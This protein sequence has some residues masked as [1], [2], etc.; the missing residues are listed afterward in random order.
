MNPLP[1]DPFPLGATI[2]EDG[3]NFSLFS[4]NAT[5]VELLLFDRP[6]AAAPSQVLRL[7]PA[8]NKT[9]FFWNI[10]LPGI[11]AGQIYG[12]RVHGPYQPEQGLRFNHN[13]VLLDP[14]ARAVANFGNWSRS[15]ALGYDPNATQRD[16]SFNEHDNCSTALKSV[17]IDSRDFDWE[18][19]QPINRRLR[20]SVIY[21]MHVRGFTKSPGSAVAHPGTFLGV[22]EKIPYLQSLGITAIE[23]LPIH[24]FDQN[25]NPFVNPFTGERLKNY[26]GYNSVNFFA[27]HPGYCCSNEGCAQVREFQTMVKALHRAGL[28][29][30]LDVAFNHTGESHELGPTISMRGVDNSVYYLLGADRR[31]YQNFSGT[32]NT[33]NCNQPIVRKMIIDSLRYWVQEM[34]VDGFRFDLASILTR[35]EDGQPLPDPPLLWEI[36]IDPTLAKTKLIAE[37]WDAAGLYQVGLFPGM[38]WAEWNGKYRDDIRRFVRGDSGM[39]PVLATRLAG[40]SDLYAPQSKRPTQSINFITAHDGFTL[41]DL[42]SYNHK[43]NEANG[44]NN[45]DGMNDNLSCNHGY[46]GPADNP[47]INA[48]RRRQIRNFAT[49]LMVSQ[50]T[51]MVLGG[52]EFLRTQLGNNNAYCQDNPIS[53]FDWSLVEENADM[54]RFFRKLIAFRRA[55]PVLR[56]RRFLAG[57]D[58]GDDLLHD[59]CWQGIDGEPADWHPFSR[60]LAVLLN[61]EKEEFDGDYDDNDVYIMINGHGDERSFVLPQPSA[62]RQWHRVVDTSL[63]SPDDIVDEGN[64][65]RLEGKAYPVRGRSVVVCIS[66]S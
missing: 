30:I 17:V 10:R 6:D 37:A 49:I 46:E 14:Y 66:K 36:E 32:G 64:E 62:A 57:K 29:V 1:G 25:D 50:G 20:N 4:R 13:R 35:G 8:V 33:L 48:L 19:D 42:V 65:V 63:S 61:G 39:V 40:S 7:E 5:G 9:F 3:V 56:R 44:E 41:N 11:R 15:A 26:W 27:L 16:L 53:W 18:G 47:A 60:A 24:V 51:P 31:Y 38:R 52:D 43:H 12:Y 55:H 58:H 22:V 45:G 23:L 21:E 34:H 59:V 28:E 54:V 2:C